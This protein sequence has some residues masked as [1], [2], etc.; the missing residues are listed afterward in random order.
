VVAQRFALAVAIGGGGL[1]L[2]IIFD[3]S[4]DMSKYFQY[5]SISI[6]MGY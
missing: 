4:V 1:F 3:L 2:L 5:A 6:I